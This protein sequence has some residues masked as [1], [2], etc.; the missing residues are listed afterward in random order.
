MSNVNRIEKKN[1]NE[2]QIFK[3][4]DFLLMNTQLHCDPINQIESVK[5]ITGIILHLG[6][7]LLLI[8]ATYRDGK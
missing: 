5:F 6:Y 4:D 7:A 2:C 1:K 3:R 8:Y